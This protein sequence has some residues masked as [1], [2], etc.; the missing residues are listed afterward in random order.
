[1]ARMKMLEET[2]AFLDRDDEEISL[3]GRSKNAAL[4]KHIKS[5]GITSVAVHLCLVLLYTAGSI[6]AIYVF[7][8][9]CRATEMGTLD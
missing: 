2:E 9:K 6:S 1:M 7:S 4:P 3:D 8:Q 5:F